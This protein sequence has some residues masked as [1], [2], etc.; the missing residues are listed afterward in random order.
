LG[1][2]YG[3]GDD[4]DWIEAIEFADGTVWDTNTIKSTAVVTP[5][6]GT[7]LDYDG[8]ASGDV[9]RGKRRVANQMQGFDGADYLFG[10]DK[11][12]VLAGGAGNDYL[13]GSSGDDTY[14]FSTGD[15]IDTIF[16]ASGDGG[17]DTLKF[18]EDVVPSSADI[19]RL[20]NDLVLTLSISDQVWISDYFGM[21]RIE[22]IVFADGTSW[23]YETVVDALTT[24]MD[25][26]KQIQC[27]PI[28]MP[29]AG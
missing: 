6:S 26:T 11:R 12:D 18:S 13:S 8:T 21:D 16:D 23:D 28:Q 3:L 22:Q 5:G 25:R 9:M 4:P 27:R 29:Q 20:S 17:F 15:G 1:Y 7:A 14:V 24:Y 19:E 10:G 2:F